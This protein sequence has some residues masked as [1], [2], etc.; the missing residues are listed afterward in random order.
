MWQCESTKEEDAEI[1]KYEFC[2]LE[3]ELRQAQKIPKTSANVGWR[4]RFL[5]V[6]AAMVMLMIFIGW[7]GI[8]IAQ[9]HIIH[10]GY[11]KGN[12]YVNWEKR[13]RAIYV[14]GLV[15]GMLLSPF[16]GAQRSKL[17]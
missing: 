9:K 5:Y 11:F 7:P 14:A 6:A 2:P 16:F 12:D 17:V 15:D 13:D 1:A 8:G 3:S 4:K 10:N